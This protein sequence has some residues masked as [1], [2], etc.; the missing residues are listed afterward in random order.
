MTHRNL[1]LIAI[2][3]GV[4]VAPLAAQYNGVPKSGM[5]TKGGMPGGITPAELKKVQFDQNLGVQVPLDLAFRDETGRA[6]Q[7]SQ[8]FNGRPVVLALVY[9][10]CPMLCTQALNGLVKALRVL[11][12][13]PG[14]DY[15]VVTV[16][17]NPKETSAQ[18]AEKKDHYLQ[19]LKKPGAADGW[20]F[21]TGD[22][23]AIRRLTGTVGFHYVYDE[24]T[25]TYAHPTGMIVLTPEGKTSK[26]VYGIDYGPRDLRLALVEA[27]DH[28]VGTPVDRLLLYCYHYDP[29]TG[30]YGLVLMNVLRIAG[31]LTV[32]CM[33]GFILIMR[34]REKRTAGA[35]PGGPANS[36]KQAQN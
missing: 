12:L 19:L 25:N 17:F 18:A 9:Y 36:D 27:S 16:S 22:E 7:L 15:N 8:Y 6:V 2:V 31:A 13:E 24:V 10:E 4:L 29:T 32:V 3:C 14:R 34:R 21:L 28:K 5:M 1:A 11:A 23:A 20:H 35:V 33:G 30:K 26:Y